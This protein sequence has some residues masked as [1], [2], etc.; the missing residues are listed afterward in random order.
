MRPRSTKCRRPGAL[1]QHN[2]EPHQRGCGGD[3]HRAHRNEA[4]RGEW[5]RGGLAVAAIFFLYELWLIRR[6]EPQ[7]CFQAFNNNH[8]VGLVVFIGLALDYLY[9]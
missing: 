9:D 5:Y 7:A 3:R 6:R 4:G 8:F 1:H 2:R